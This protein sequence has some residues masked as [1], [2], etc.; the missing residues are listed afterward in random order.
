MAKQGLVARRAARD[1]MIA[2]TEGG[3]MLGDAMRDILGPLAPSDRARAQRLATEAL[4]WSG[5]ADRLL[6]P[7]LRQRPSEAVLNTLRLALWEILG[8]GSPAHAVVDSAVEIAR[9][10]P[11]TR[12]SAGMVNAVLRNVLRGDVDWEALPPPTLPKWLRKPLLADY[13]KETVAAIEAAQLRG[14]ALDLTAKAGL[15]AQVADAIQGTILPTG[16]IRLTGQPQVSALPG[17]ETGDWWVQD[18]AAALPARILAPQ[19]G[20]RV[21]DLCAAPGGKTLQLADAG[22]RVTAVDISD[23]RLGRLRENLAR[24]GLEAEVVVADALTWDAAGGFDAVLI[25]APCS[26][27]GTIR[28][29]PDLP[30][31]KAGVELSGLL[32]LQSGLIDRAVALTR[33][34]G[35][36]VYCTCSLLKDEGERQ[37]DAALARHPDLA[38]LPPDAP[39]IAPEWITE[40][41]GLRLR[42][43]YWPEAGGLDGFFI[44]LLQKPA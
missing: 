12:R 33:P 8:D 35:R 13:G 40:T 26:A 28:R 36:I 23:A 30:F 38:V 43:D 31:A 14:A 27:T 41:G 25:D 18:A 17:F 29:H 22:A 15:G 5:R 16:S 7:Y 44:A 3:Q 20:D 39:G 19:R 37:L 32:A 34:G 2:V 11:E 24:T 9:A 21:L 6:G 4:R 1:L 42:P 10:V